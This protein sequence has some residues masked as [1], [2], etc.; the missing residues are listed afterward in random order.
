MDNSHVGYC[1]HTEKTT[2]Y[3]QTVE[4]VQA[5]LSENFICSPLV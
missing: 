5:M 2:T 3:K 1:T 4:S